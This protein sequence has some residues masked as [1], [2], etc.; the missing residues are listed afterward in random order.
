MKSAMASLPVLT[1]HSLDDLG[2]VTSFSPALFEQ[3]LA[4]LAARGYRTLGLAELVESLRQ[5]RPLPER[6]LVITFDDGHASV[7][8]HALP[9]LRRHGL[10]ATIFLTVGAQSTGANDGERLPSFEGRPLL[11]WRE[12]EELRDAGMEF[13][14]HTLTHPDLT[15]LDRRAAEQELS[16]AK[17]LIE[18][19]L[20]VP[21]IG[22]AYPYGRCDA[23]VR[24]QAAA[25]FSC[26]F[27]D[28]LGLVT[29]FDD[30]LMLSRVDA[31]YLR[32]PRRFRRFLSPRFPWYL[33]VRGIARQARRRLI[34]ASRSRS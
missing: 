5:W 22:C 27:T 34:G 1:F 26:A 12:I 17:E 31:Y 3:A 18:K 21:V 9:V 29:P 8:T 30:P 11:A 10:R 15:R 2:H 33:A 4:T 32:T 28:R 23:R 7:Y 20:G 14:A 13:G 6:T 16:G 24:A 25:H 19:R